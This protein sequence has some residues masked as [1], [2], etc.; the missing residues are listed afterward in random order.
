[1]IPTLKKFLNKSPNSGRQRMIK[2]YTSNF[3]I[4]G[5]KE[6]CRRK[7]ERKLQQGNIRDACSGMK[8]ITRFKHKE[9]QIHGFLDRVT[10]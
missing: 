7:L 5:S 4:Q 10:N 8:N 6:K 9:A 1:M 2:A 3:K